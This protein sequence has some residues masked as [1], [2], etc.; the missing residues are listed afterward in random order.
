LHQELVTLKDE[1]VN[2]EEGIERRRLLPEEEIEKSVKQNIGPKKAVTIKRR[3]EN[4]ERELSRLQEI[5]RIYARQMLKFGIASWIFGLSIFF[6][7]AIILDPSLP[8]RMSP[9]SISLLALAAA[10][11]ISITGVGIR[12]FRVKID[13]ME[14]IRGTLLAS[15]RR[16]ILDRMVWSGK[17]QDRG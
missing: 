7:A 16:D 14:C 8:G 12:N 15:Y 3:L 17:I 5:Q 9:V 6:L 11:P 1:R 10:G 13:R 4:L 2:L